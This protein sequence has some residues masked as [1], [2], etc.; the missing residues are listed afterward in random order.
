MLELLSAI[1]DLL[2]LLRFLMKKDDW[3]FVYLLAEF[4]ITI[5]KTLHDFCVT[6]SMPAHYN[7]E[8]YK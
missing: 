8:I 6:E 7:N 3:Y 1:L 2:E 4:K 5:T